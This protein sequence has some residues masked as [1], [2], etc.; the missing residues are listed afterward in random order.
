VH[1]HE[2]IEGIRQQVAP[3]FQA[4]CSARARHHVMPGAE[5]RFVATYSR[6]SVARIV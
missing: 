1:A 4:Q 2:R 5:A 3:H 6:M